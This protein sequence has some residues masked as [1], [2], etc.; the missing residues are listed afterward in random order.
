MIT[1]HIIRFVVYIPQP[2]AN[3]VFRFVRCIRSKI[4]LYRGHGLFDYRTVVIFDRTT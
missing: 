3:H 2:R 4:F 1:G